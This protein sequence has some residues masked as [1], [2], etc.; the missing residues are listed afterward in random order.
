MVN[1]GAWEKVAALEWGSVVEPEGLREVDWN[2]RLGS[3]GRRSVRQ[4][5]SCARRGRGGGGPTDVALDALTSRTART[6]ARAQSLLARRHR[7]TPS[8][9]SHAEGRLRAHP[10]AYRLGSAG[11]LVDGQPTRWCFGGHVEVLLVGVV[12]RRGVVGRRASGQHLVRV[13][14]SCEVVVLIW[15]RATVRGWREKEAGDGLA[16][17]R[18]QSRSAKGRRVV[19]VMV[20]TVDQNHDQN[21]NPH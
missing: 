9:S 15:R 4:R 18:S 10:L 3:A 14:L 6:Q 13:P 5:E 12:D 19:M 1:G 20:I 8:S 2:S 17:K 21:W 16:V 7:T 11:V